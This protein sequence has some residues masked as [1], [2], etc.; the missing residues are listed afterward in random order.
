MKNSIEELIEAFRKAMEKHH[1]TF[2]KDYLYFLDSQITSAR[3]QH[4]DE[5]TEAYFLGRMHGEGELEMASLYRLKSIVEDT[6]E[7][8]SKTFKQ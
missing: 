2:D 6:T 1:Y 8:Y 3:K 5:V 7:Y 4:K